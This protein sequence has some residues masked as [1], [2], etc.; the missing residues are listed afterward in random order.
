VEILR[1]FSRRS[2]EIEEFLARRGWHGPGARRTAAAAT[3]EPKDLTTSYEA[4]QV[5]WRERAIEHGLAVGRLDRLVERGRAQ[6]RPDGSRAGEIARGL[7]PALGATGLTARRASFTRS[8]LLRAACRGAPEGASVA[9]V[10]RTVDALCGSPALV[11]RGSG[12]RWLHREGGR[13]IPAPSA[14][15]RFTTPEI[16]D[17]EAS[18]AEAVRSRQAIGAAVATER[19]AGAALGCRPL[20]PAVEVVAERLL[21]AG[22]GVEVLRAAE[23]GDPG[24][25]AVGGVQS[26]ALDAARDGW[27]RDGRQVFGLA[28]TAPG[29]RRLE[30]TTGVE[31]VPV[32]A[33]G[34]TPREV[35]L[36][37]AAL[38]SGSVLAVG[39]AERLGPRLTAAV[40]EGAGLA[41]AKVVLSA[42]GRL[43]G[44]DDAV[45]AD[46]AGLHC[47]GIG[48]PVPAPFR[49]PE[50]GALQATWIEAGP[51]L[52][53]FA[54]SAADARQVLIGTW[55]DYA[56]RDRTAV[57][58]TDDQWTGL[59]L[60]SAGCAPV[61]PP[62]SLAGALANSPGAALV[63]LGDAGSL[64]AAVRRNPRIERAHVAIER[65]G[66]ARRRLG[67]VEEM[68]LQPRVVREIGAPPR[69][70]EGRSAWRAAADAWRV[71]E[72]GRESGDRTT[73]AGGDRAAEA[74]LADALRTLREL[75]PG[76]ARSLR[77]GREIGR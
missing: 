68:A 8:E 27:E 36:S 65:V 67:R 58:V 22:H 46:L 56:A 49:S 4:L 64:P 45:L 57:V 33:L 20:A 55:L 52:V 34:R 24:R 71:R 16:L 1:A 42:A 38:P 11:E 21:R 32:E 51:A 26:D 5:G 29:A 17:I 15:A 30:A 59:A 53:T 10:E 70:F 66:D 9:E 37:V 74:L 61:V 7:G 77:T 63:V 75:R 73:V 50:T 69:T 14:E 23:P 39:A 41:Q 72:L 31:S 12:R 76:R 60:R 19:S 25:A 2:A 18:I 13:S 6:A 43:T 3:R 40:L 35:M 62:R 47:P 54:R 28:P 44:P 48:T